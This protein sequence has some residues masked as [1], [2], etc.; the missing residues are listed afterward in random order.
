L[1]QRLDA[2]RARHAVAWRWVKGH[3]ADPL[4]ARADRLAR[5]ALERARRAG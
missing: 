5:A 3:A 4:N 2:A 1:W